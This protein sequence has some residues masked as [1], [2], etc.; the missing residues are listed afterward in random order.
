MKS[1]HLFQALVRVGGRR[2][3]QDAIART[4]SGPLLLL[5]L[6][7]IKMEEIVFINNSHIETG[8][9]ASKKQISKLAVV[10][11]RAKRRIRAALEELDQESVRSEMHKRHIGKMRL[12]LVVQREALV[13]PFEDLKKMLHRGLVKLVSQL[14][15]PQKDINVQ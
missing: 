14:P 11:N 9:V 8:I 10:R 2:S 1:Q 12:L 15:P 6:T 4:R 5:C 7:A 3:R 13:L